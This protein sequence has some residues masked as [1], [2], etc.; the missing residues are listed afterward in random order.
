MEL[1]TLA[2]SKALQFAA[3]LSLKDVILEGELE[4][5]INALNVDSYSLA[6]FGL[7]S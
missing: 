1:E 6:S 4:I 3:D 7:F 5:V 2:P